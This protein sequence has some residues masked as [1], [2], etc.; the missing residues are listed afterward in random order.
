MG[1]DDVVGAVEAASAAIARLD[2]RVSLSPLRDAWQ[3]RAAARAAIALAAI[4]GRHVRE[5]DL[6]GMMSGAALPVASSYLGAGT[7]LA[8]WR[9]AVGRADLSEATQLLVGRKVTRARRAAEDQADWDGEDA[10]SRGARR[11]LGNMM[12]GRGWID[13]DRQAEA[14]RLR[15]L[16]AM[17]SAGDGLPAIARGLRDALAVDRDPDRHGRVHDL[18]SLVARQARERLLADSAGL[19]AEVVAARRDALDDMLA[20]LDWEAPRGLG[21]AHMAVADRLVEMGASS[22][23]LSIL[24][25]ATKRVAVER[26]GDVRATCGFLRV[27]AR[28]ASEGLVL[29]SA[30]ES[31]VAAWASTPGIAADARSSLPAVLWAV[32]VLPVVDAGWIGEACGLEPRVV[33]KFLKRL[34]DAGAIAPWAERTPDGT[35]GRASSV[36]LWVARVFADELARH[37]TRARLPLATRLAFPDVLS[38]SAGLSSFAPMAEVFARHDR[39]MVDIDAA[40]G[41]LWRRDGRTSVRSPAV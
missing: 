12:I 25:G 4:D 35:T 18:S 34:A 16:E 29:L 41:R 21:E 6:V 3:V 2:V 20:S 11:A 24:T 22:M 13:E 9:R 8:W 37:E 30:L 32:L 7:A 15:A 26:R 23:R 28:E 14:A 27:L 31:T 17:R 10:M 19:G 38:R 5:A 39:E 40:F 1:R 36:R 33:Q